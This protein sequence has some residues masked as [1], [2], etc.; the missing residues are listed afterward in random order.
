GG[1]TWDRPSGAPDVVDDREP[2][3]VRIAGGRGGVVSAPGRVVPPVGSGGDGAS[4]SQATRR[5]STSARPP[6]RSCNN[7][8]ENARAT[9]RRRSNAST[10]FGAYSVSETFS[11][12]AAATSSY[13]LRLRNATSSAWLNDRV[14]K[15]TV[16]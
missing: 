15:S 3:T 12:T 10:T 1:G 11:V 8:W 6:E 5:A 2:A 4:S 7:R 9:R 13:S 16:A 14:K